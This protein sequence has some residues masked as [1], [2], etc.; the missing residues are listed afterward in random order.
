[1]N[2]RGSTGY[3]LNFLKSLEGNA[4]IYD[5]EDC[6]ELLLK[7]IEEYKAEIDET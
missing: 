5:V 3:G 7:T 4:G 2:Y 6:G 1:M